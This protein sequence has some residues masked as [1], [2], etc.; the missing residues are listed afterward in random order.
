M[1]RF[2]DFNGSGILFLNPVVSG[3]GE[4]IVEANHVFHLN[5]GWN[6]AKLDQSSF[7]VKRPGQTKTVFVYQLF[8]VATIEEAIMELID[9]KREISVA[10]LEAAEDNLTKSD[11]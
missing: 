7:R 9:N 8:Y 2:R 11:D 5:P 1:E 6:P 10:A 3:E 4:T